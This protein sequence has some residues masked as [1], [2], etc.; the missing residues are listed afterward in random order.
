MLVLVRRL[1]VLRL[2]LR[3]CC[4]HPWLLLLLL[5]RL[6][7]LRFS[8]VTLRNAHVLGISLRFLLVLLRLLLLQVR[9]RRRLSRIVARR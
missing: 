7:L 5:L 9:L 2:F 8:L 3:R 6:R 1:L 4:R